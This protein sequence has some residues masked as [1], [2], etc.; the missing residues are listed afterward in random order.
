MKNTPVFGQFILALS[1][2]SACHFG[3]ER[4]VAQL[5]DARGQI[6]FHEDTTIAAKPAPGSA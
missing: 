2:V 1:S 4:F 6:S 3:N 5:L